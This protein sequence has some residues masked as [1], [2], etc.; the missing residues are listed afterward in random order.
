M[1]VHAGTAYLLENL[2]TRGYAEDCSADRPGRIQWRGDSRQ[3]DANG[4]RAG[5][6][7][8]GQGGGNGLLWTWSR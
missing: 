3:L 4:G 1:T 7:Q 8:H 2:A 5:Y 6:S